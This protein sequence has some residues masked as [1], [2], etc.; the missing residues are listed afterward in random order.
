MKTQIIKNILI[1]DVSKADKELFFGPFPS[2]EAFER[3]EDNAMLLDI[4]VNVKIMPSKGECRRNGWHREIKEGY[5]EVTVGKLKHKL[6]MLKLT[7]E[8]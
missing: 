5:S 3:F 6:Y 2:N 4:L 1:G 7:K 8:V